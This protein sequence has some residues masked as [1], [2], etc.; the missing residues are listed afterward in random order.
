MGLD[1]VPL[2]GGWLVGTDDGGLL[3]SPLPPPPPL[4][5][6]PGRPNLYPPTHTPPPLSLPQVE[7]K[8]AVRAL[9]SAPKRWRAAPARRHRRPL[10]RALPLRPGGRPGELSRVAGAALARGGEPLPAAAAPAGSAGFQ[11]ASGRD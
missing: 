3:S 5:S 10:A 11:G 7:R 6:S 9:V 8:N 1:A 4:P 2:G